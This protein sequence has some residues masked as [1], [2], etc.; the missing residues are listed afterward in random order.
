MSFLPH[1]LLILFMGGQAQALSLSYV[2]ETSIKTGAEFQKTTIGGLSGIV[3]R[4]G[5]LLALSDDKGRIG[6]PRFY[7]F[8]LKVTS[9][10]VTLKPLKVHFIS[11]LPV[12]GERKVS[13]DPE[14]LAGLPSGDLLVSSEGNNDSKPR[15]MPRVF[16]VSA[17]GAW[18]ADLP[19][20]DKFLPESTGQQKK[21]V[22]NNAA[23]EGLSVTADGKYAFTSVETSLF[24]DYVIGEEEKGDWIRILKYEEKSEKGYQPVYEYAYRV[25]PLTDAHGGKEVFRGVSEVLAVSETKLLVL[26]RGVRLFPKKIWANTVALY[27]VD[28]SKGT[29]VSGLLKLEGGKFT[30]VSKKLLVDFE[31]DLKKRKDKKVQNFETLSWGPK[32]SDG[33]R[34]LL[35]MSDNNFSKKEITELVVFAVEGE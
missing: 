6:E 12:T 17:V 20:P 5:R 25:E 11:G 33:R 23:F 32:L 4:D 18:K 29:D 28:L 21:G 9:S 3:W 34:S 7:E 1:A 27:E 24:Q 19:V 26:E 30:G 31:V 14:G 15:E 2:G 8:D 16:Q 35:V 22:Q 10:S 13:L